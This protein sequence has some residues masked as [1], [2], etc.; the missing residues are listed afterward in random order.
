MTQRK[1]VIV[2]LAI[3]LL[4]Y[5][6]IGYGTPE[7]DWS[8][9]PVGSVAENQPIGTEVIRVTAMNPDNAS[10]TFYPKGGAADFSG[11]RGHGA[12]TIEGDGDTAVIKTR[13]VLDYETQNFYTLMVSVADE[14]GFGDFICVDINVTNDPSDDTTNEPNR[15][16]VFTEG[17]SVT[18][19]IS[20]DASPGTVIGSPLTATDP[21]GDP[22]SYSL[23]IENIWET[24]GIILEIDFDT[25]ALI[26]G[27]DVGSATQSSYRAR[28]FA[29]DGKGGKDYI[30]VTINILGSGQ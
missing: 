22:V 21:D 13:V 19:S 2:I 7:F 27:T 15:P 17:E 1:A 29:N 30:D 11:N 18:R 9:Y 23:W 20:I 8:V 25:G 26:V 28:V 12:F 5:Q 14:T 4:I 3:T 16:P 10:L 24:Y 6:G